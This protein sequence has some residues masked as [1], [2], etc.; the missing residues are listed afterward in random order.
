MKI[1]HI[2]EQWVCGGIESVLTDLCTA[3]SKRGVTNQ[4]AHLYEATHRGSHA[5]PLTSE[6]VHMKRRLRVDPL[7]LRRLH[8]VIN[9]EKP[10]VLHCHGYYAAAS[11]LALRP[12]N[13]IPLLYTVHSDLGSG[14]E[15]SRGFVAGVLRRC[16]RVVAVSSSAASTV[17]GFTDGR[18]RADVIRNGI[19][20]GRME[21]PQGFCAQEKLRSAGVPPDAR[22]LCCAAALTTQKD[23]TTLLKA[24]AQLRARVDNVVLV[25]LGDGPERGRLEVLASDLRLGDAVRFL[26]TRKDVNEWMAASGGF[27]LSSHAEGTPISIIEAACAGLPVAATAVGGVPGLAK[28]GLEIH[29]AAPGNEDEL[30][31]AMQLAMLAS[32]AG[33]RAERGERARAIL[34]IGATADQY[35]TI[36]EELSTSRCGR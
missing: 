6:P 1:Q 7:G 17:D 32:A 35:C 4:L 30:V 21:T 14:T 13:R 29:L 18:V 27:V 33:H 25:I 8:R 24:F 12:F 34:G 5:G 31:T 11:A 9:Q 16:D 15:R 26:G 2:T 22:V 3:T 19:D 10:D 28:E 23:H 20:S 36:Y